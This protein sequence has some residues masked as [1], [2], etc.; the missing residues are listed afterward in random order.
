MTLPDPQSLA[1]ALPDKNAVA[2]AKKKLEGRRRQVRA[3]LLDRLARPA[4][5]QASAA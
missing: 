4:K 1:E 2:A 3:V 5:D